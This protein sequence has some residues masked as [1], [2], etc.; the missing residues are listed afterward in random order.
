MVGAVFAEGGAWRGL[1]WAFALQCLAF[2]VAAGWLL[3]D[4]PGPEAGRTP[5]LQLAIVLL[6][7][8]LVGAADLTASPLAAGVL[9]AASL[10]VFVASVKIPVDIRDSLFPREAGDPTSVIGAAYVSFFALTAA[11]TGFTVYGPALLQKLF[12]LSPLF[13]GYAA[14]LESLGWTAAALAVAGL[15]ERWHAPILRLGGACV[16]AGLAVLAVAMRAG[17]LWAIL[18]AATVLGAGFG[19]T[20]GYTARR[21]IAAAPVDERELA[22]AGI[23]SVRQVGNAAGAC[24][25]GIIANLLGLAAG[26]TQPAAEAAAVWLFALATPVALLGAAGCWRVAAARQDLTAGTFG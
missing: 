26:V 22:S 13:A 12:R 5:W 16:V 24:M 9:C 17:P 11:A 3:R 14:G 6:G 15:S 8:G 18:A 21:V 25:A 1:F 20:S 7:V 19:L 10:V 23:N 4:S 2:T